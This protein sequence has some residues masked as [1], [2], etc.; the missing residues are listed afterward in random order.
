MF[1]YVSPVRSI[2]VVTVMFADGDRIVLEGTPDEVVYKGIVRLRSRMPLYPSTSV[3][4]KIMR[5]TCF[6]YLL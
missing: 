1:L 2:T 3:G 6:F 4:T 5:R